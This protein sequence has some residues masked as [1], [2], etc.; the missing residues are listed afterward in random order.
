MTRA[1]VADC[2]FA[3][4][5]VAEAAIIRFAIFWNSIVESSDSRASSSDCG[6]DR[7]IGMHSLPC[8]EVRFKHQEPP[9]EPQDRL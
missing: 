1:L 8:V 5:D 9:E 7:A 4:S 6:L 2:I 3:S